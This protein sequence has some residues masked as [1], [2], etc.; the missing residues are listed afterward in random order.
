MPESRFPPECPLLEPDCR[1]L[2]EVGR[3]RAENRELRQQVITDSLTG[4][5]NYRYFSQMLNTEMQRTRRT[6]QPTCLIMIDLDH[7]K[8]VN[9]RWGHEGGNVALQT[10]ARVFRQELRQLDIVCRYGGEE[11]AVILPQTTLPMAAAIAERIRLS[12]GQTPVAFAGERFSLTASFGVDCYRS[13]DPDSAEAFVRRVD[14]WLYL[15]KEAGRNRVAH[16]PFS[17]SGEPGEVS[18]DERAEL[19]GKR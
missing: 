11:F 15:A 14:H 2:R 9:D 13:T 16:P 5:F 6:G 3:L 17:G 4:L 12:L 19:L 10:V 18:P 1:W 7:F 8:K